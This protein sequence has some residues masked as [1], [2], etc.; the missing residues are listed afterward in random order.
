MFGS[1]GREDVFIYCVSLNLFELQQF[2]EDGY[3]GLFWCAGVHYLYLY[4]CLKLNF[5]NFAERDIVLLRRSEPS[6]S[7]MTRTMTKPG[8]RG[9]ITWWVLPLNVKYIVK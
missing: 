4:L 7:A 3:C 6:L 1:F 8:E 2:R 5:R 9:S